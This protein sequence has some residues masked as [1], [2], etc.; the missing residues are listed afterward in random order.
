MTRVAKENGGGG[1]RRKRKRGIRNG[2][3]RITK[4]IL[5]RKN[6]IN[7]GETG[8]FIGGI[9]RIGKIEFAISGIL[10]RNDGGGVTENVG[11]RIVH[12]RVL[13]STMKRMARILRG[14][15]GIVDADSLSQFCD[16]AGEIVRAKSA[17]LVTLDN[18][19]VDP[20]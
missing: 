11:N 10:A 7:E 8:G 9:R 3:G 13:D 19:G 12:H 2:I 18:G 6:G 16:R 5:G 17:Y 1:N 14:R 4:E 20:T 15:G